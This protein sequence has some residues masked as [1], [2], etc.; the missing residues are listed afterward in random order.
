MLLGWNPGL[1]VHALPIHCFPSPKGV[2]HLVPWD[3]EKNWSVLWRQQTKPPLLSV[4][5]R[6]RR[7]L[8][9][10]TLEDRVC[11][12]SGLSLVP[13]SCMHVGYG[14]TSALRSRMLMMNVFI[15][16]K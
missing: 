7:V 8:L 5:L 4:I 10:S 13:V 12:D 9:E 2:E 1:W 11:Q 16:L 3:I 6:R 15:F 14:A